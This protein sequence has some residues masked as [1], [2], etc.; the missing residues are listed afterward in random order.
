MF[1]TLEVLDL[2]SKTIGRGEHESSVISGCLLP[3]T[4]SE[5]ES[6]TVYRRKFYTTLPSMPLELQFYYAGSK[7][8]IT[9]QYL[10]Y[11]IENVIA[12]TGGFLGLL[13]GYSLLGFYDMAKSALGK[14]L[15]GAPKLA[16]KRSSWKA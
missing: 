11:D 14:Y 12:D 4:Q 3:C 6:T 8:D 10:A 7:Y 15:W 5:F 2:Y 13:L 1:Q 9:S 16:I